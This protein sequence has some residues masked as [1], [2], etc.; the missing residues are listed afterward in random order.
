MALAAALA[1]IPGTSVTLAA[2]VTP[3]ASPSVA[4]TPVP[5]AYWRVTDRKAVAVNGA[6]I[7]SMAPD[8]TTFVAASPAD[9][10]EPTSLC[11]YAV[12]T[13]G[14]IACADLSPLDS[15][16]IADIAWAPDGSALALSDYGY[17]D[18]IDSDLWLMDAATGSLTNIADDGFSG[19]FNVGTKSPTPGTLTIPVNPAFTPDGTGVTYS[20]STI[21]DGKEVGND[22]VTVPLS[23]GNPRTVVTVSSN[24][25]AVVRHGLEWAPDGSKLY[26]AVEHLQ[27]GDPDNGIWVVNADGSDAHQLVAEAEDQ[28]LAVIQMAADGAHLLSLDRMNAYMYFRDP[29]YSVVDTTTGASQALVPLDPA[30]PP[31]A[32]VDWAGFAPDGG[33]LLTLTNKTDPRTGGGDRSL[34]ANVRDIG[35]TVEEQL[36]LDPASEARNDP[37]IPLVWAA[38]GVALLTGGDSLSSAIAIT[39]GSG[40]DPATDSPHASASATP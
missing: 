31:G 23:G 39:I 10:Q 29:I 32:W 4:P 1:A 9:S 14:Q 22:I 3:S 24:E 21:T 7:I 35:A 6:R 27:R 13:G 18:N 8:G 12:A 16:Q 25:A 15:L 11:T 2:S 34:D 33:S 30:S 20:R 28:E 26:Y 17:A 19:D 38:N 5:A 36:L 37:S 40:G